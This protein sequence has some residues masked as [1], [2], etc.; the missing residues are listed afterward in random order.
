MIETGVAQGISTY[1]ILKAMNDNR[2][3]RLISIDY[4]N[5]NPEGYVDESGKQDNVY[6]PHGL[7]PGWI[8]PFDSTLRNRWTLYIG[9]SMD[10]LPKLQYQDIDAF[11]HDSDHSYFNMKRELAWAAMNM[12]SGIII[13]D[14]TQ[15][16]G[17]WDEFSARP[18]MRR[19]P[20]PISAVE[21]SQGSKVLQ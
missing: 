5:R 14:D 18:C 13:A 12:K 17:A 8:I 11:F 1:F 20:S 19:I 6:L 2:K 10:V 15:L 9:R 3:G 4:P 7:E 21:I 16:N